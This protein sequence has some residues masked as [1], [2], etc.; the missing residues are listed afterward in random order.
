MEKKKS[1]SSNLHSEEYMAGS[2]FSSLSGARYTSSALSSSSSSY[3]L[4]EPRL[5]L[6]SCCAEQEHAKQTNVKKQIGA[7]VVFIKF[8]FSVLNNER[9][10]MRTW[11]F[12]VP[13]KQSSAV[14]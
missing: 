11:F 14:V 13:N 6:F 2:S 1:P 5:C 7:I 9:T 4:F 3:R 10:Y 8:V 12:Q